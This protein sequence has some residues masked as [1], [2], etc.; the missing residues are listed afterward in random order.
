MVGQLTFGWASVREVINEP[1]WPD[2]SREHFQESASFAD[3]LEFDPDYQRI[4]NCNDIGVYRAWTARSGGRLVGYIGWWVQ[5]LIDSRRTLCAVDHL[6]VMAP[7]YR[8]GLNGYSM[9]RSCF[10]ALKESGVKMIMVHSKTSLDLTKLM[11]R[12]GLERIETLWGG[13]L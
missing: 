6:Y 13:M 4:I 12:L 11:E 2:L 5:P 9:F 7:E 8:Q 1:N 10:A 3:S